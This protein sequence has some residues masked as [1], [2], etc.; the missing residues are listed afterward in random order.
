MDPE[1][2]VF[3]QMK[4]PSYWVLDILYN[5][6]AIHATKEDETSTDSGKQEVSEQTGSNNSRPPADTEAAFSPSSLHCTSR[7]QAHE[8]RGNTYYPTN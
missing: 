1:F 7:D 4:D 6:L 2:E 3:R 5:R 8:P